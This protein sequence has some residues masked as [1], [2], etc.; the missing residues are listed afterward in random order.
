M[1]S[2]YDAIKLKNLQILKVDKKIF[3][4]KLI[5][6]EFEQSRYYNI[7]I[8]RDPILGWI[9]FLNELIYKFFKFHNCKHLEKKMEKMTLQISIENGILARRESF[10]KLLLLNLLIRCFFLNNNNF[11]RFSLFIITYSTIVNVT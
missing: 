10:M 2:E 5:K 6:R 3:N 8:G 9:K 4:A 11:K 1:D 7:N